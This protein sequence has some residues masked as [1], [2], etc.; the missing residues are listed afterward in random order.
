M[1]RSHNFRPSYLRLRASLLRRKLNVQCVFAMTA[2]ATI[3]T[4]EEIVNALE[5]PYDNLIK[6]SQIR[7]NL[8]LSISMSDNRYATFSLIVL[9]AVLELFNMVYL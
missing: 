5:I 7:E 4:V 2:T 3:Q 9:I 8:Q 6:T 1:D